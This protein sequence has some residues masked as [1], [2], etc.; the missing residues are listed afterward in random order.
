MSDRFQPEIVPKTFVPNSQTGVHNLKPHVINFSKH[1]LTAAQTRLLSKGLKFCPVPEEPDLLELEVNMKEWIRKL[2]IKLFMSNTGS[3]E[4]EYLLSRPGQFIPPENNEKNFQAVNNKIISEAERLEKLPKPTPKNNLNFDEKQ[5]LKELKNNTDLV[6]RPFDKGSGICIFDKN[7]Y[8]NNISGILDNPLYENFENNP[9]FEVIKQFHTFIQKY[10]NCFDSKGKEIDYLT[11]FD[12]ETANFYGNPKIHKCSHVKNIINSTN[13]VSAQV[14]I[15]E[16]HDLKF[17]CITAGKHSPLSKLSELLDILLKPFVT[18][19]QSHIRDAM[20]FKNKLRSVDRTEIQ[21]IIIVTADVSDMYNNLKLP[22]GIR[23]INHWLNLFPELLHHRFS[24]D[25]VIEALTLVLSNANFQFNGKFYNLKQGTVTGTTVSPTYAT[26]TMAYLE[27]SLY[28]KVKSKYGE[29]IERYV[30]TNWKRFL[31]DGHILWKKSFGPVQEFVDILNS[32]D[33]DIKFTFDTSEIGLPFLQLF[34]YK[35][36]DTIQTDIYYKE[37]D[38]HDYLPFKSSHPRHT[39]ENIP[40]NLARNICALVDCPNQVNFRMQE[41]RTWLLRGGYHHDL[42]QN[43]INKAKSIDRNRL[44]TKT[45]GEKKETLPFIITHN[46][47]NPHVY[48]I[49]VQNFDFLKSTDQYHGA[50]SKIKLVKS[51]RQ[52]KNLYRHLV[53]SNVI[54]KTFTPGSKKCGISRCGTCKFLL[55]CNSV[56]FPAA[57][58]IFKLKDQFDCTSG[59]LIYKI[60]CIACDEYY[61]GLTVHLRNRV[62]KHNYDRRH[63]EHRKM[64]VHKHLYD[65]IDD[66]LDNPFEEPCYTIVPFFKV[67]NPTPA[68]LQATEDYFVRK[69]KPALNTRKV[70]GS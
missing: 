40:F 26:L 11:N 17:R 3:N 39:M 6:I 65:C 60:T 68:R 27:L 10:N 63:L 37:T 15:T 14:D 33:S 25:F 18:K 29:T 66:C 48:N 2:E 21:D 36:I 31:D 59:G 58:T 70:R 45:V 23:S 47:K 51:E 57:H 22:L 67:Y 32:L 49:I 64:K 30:R 8:I 62:N 53:H 41:L 20:D 24:Q 61:I 50:L 34:V 9:D 52:P 7:V 54:K 35:T 44:L 38:G 56:P 19:I 69:F 12:F 28:Q 42:V 16:V 46:P 43:A 1:V 5:A 13:S 55:E 4:S